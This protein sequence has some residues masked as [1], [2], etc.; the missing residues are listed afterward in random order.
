VRTID[1]QINRVLRHEHALARLAGAFGG[2]AIALAAVGLFGLLSYNVARRTRE[3]GI[4]IALG[5]SR[6]RLIGMV[7]REAMVLVVFGAAIGLVAGPWSARLIAAQL[8]AIAPNDPVTIA[9]AP[10]LL[11][12][13]G[14]IAGYLPARRVSMVEAVMALRE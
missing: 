11:I 6:P 10:A 7:M 8:Y 5:A 9:V 4:R 2:V 13:V 14:A 3:I 12:M 1:E